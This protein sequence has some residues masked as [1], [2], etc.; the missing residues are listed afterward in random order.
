MSFVSTL[1]NL[2]TNL[3]T[4][5][6]DDV[7]A[8]AG[9]TS[10]KSKI[11]VADGKVSF[12]TSAYNGAPAF[13]DSTFYYDFDKQMHVAGL[14]TC[15]GISSSADI[16][17]S[18]LAAIHAQGALNVDG[19]S[20]LGVLAAGNSS[21]T[22][23]LGVSGTSNLADLNA[24]NISASGTLGVTGASTLAGLGATNISA[25]GTLGVT[26]TSSLGVLNAGNS[27]I[28]GTLGVSG[29]SSLGAL[30][31]G[32]SSITGTLGVSGASSLGALNAGNSSI[33]GTL[34][35][36]GTSSLGVLTA[37][38][39]SITGTLGVSGVSTF[40]SA[41]VGAT[42]DTSQKLQ[43]YGLSTIGELG[44]TDSTNISTT[45]LDTLTVYGNIVCLG[46]TIDGT[47]VLGN[48][49]GADAT[50][51]DPAA[52]ADVYNETLTTILTGIMARLYAIGA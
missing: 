33:T 30:N 19:T 10:F 1:T 25:S 22:G 48:I 43:S 14:V 45:A 17:T 41:T 8:L 34:G 49:G 26:G 16:T 37:G 6:V 18:P 36:S 42:G 21:I 2:P 11:S 27:S 40:G 13:N 44:I 3:N 4:Y 51:H 35:V 20:T 52:N 47:V 39:S 46:G 32:N 9:K 23:T 50:Y 15:T 7:H 29:A 12:A 5:F 31:A 24:T 28:T 38:N